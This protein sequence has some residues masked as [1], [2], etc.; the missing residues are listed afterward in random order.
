[1]SSIYL[2]TGESDMPRVINI[3]G[4]GSHL[5]S[6]NKKVKIFV[7]FFEEFQFDTRIFVSFN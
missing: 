2:L 7:Y 6:Y 3:T 5:Q 1:M 4:G